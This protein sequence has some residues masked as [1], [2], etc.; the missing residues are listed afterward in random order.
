MK[1]G[2]GG[3]YL[4]KQDPQTLALWHQIARNRGV[5]LNKLIEAAMNREIDEE[6]REL[7][8]AETRPMF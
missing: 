6:R 3:T 5:S 8:R 7:G 2:P 4:V 1:G